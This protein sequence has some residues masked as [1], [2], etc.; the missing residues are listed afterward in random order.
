MHM[1]TLPLQQPLSHLDPL[2]ACVGMQ[3]VSIHLESLSP[4]LVYLRE[5]LD[6]GAGF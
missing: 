6:K 4:S 3:V 2:H 5:P 1:E